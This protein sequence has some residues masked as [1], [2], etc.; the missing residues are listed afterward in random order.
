[1]EAKS[2]NKAQIEV[3]NAL[4]YLHTEED[5]IAL[6]QALSDFFAKR[7]DEEM[8]RLIASGQWSDASL[9]SLKNSHYR[10]P[11]R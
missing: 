3:L 2:L 8:E 7:A 4:A 10:T 6:K 5:I 1:M 11:Y 9:E